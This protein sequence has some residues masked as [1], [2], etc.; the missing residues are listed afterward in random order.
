MSRWTS[1]RKVI[2]WNGYVSCTE[3]ELTGESLAEHAYDDRPIV[4]DSYALPDH[5]LEAPIE[6][7]TTMALMNRGRTK[8]VK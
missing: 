8:K 6:H 2:A 5:V 1:R 7:F 3:M 4:H